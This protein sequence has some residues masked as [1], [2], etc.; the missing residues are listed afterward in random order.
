MNFKLPII[1]YRSV[2]FKLPIILYRSVNFK[3]PMTLYRSVNFKLPIIFFSRFLLL[4]MKLV[5]TQQSHTPNSMWHD[6]LSC[7]RTEHDQS[8]NNYVCVCVHF[9]V[10]LSTLIFVSPIYSLCV[11]HSGIFLHHTLSLHKP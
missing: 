1:L 5:A 3:L 6:Y 10:S 11:T 8:N 9:I 7:P 2:N 4:I